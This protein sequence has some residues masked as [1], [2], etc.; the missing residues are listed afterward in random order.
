MIKGGIKVEKSEIMKNRKRCNNLCSL[1]H[2][3]SN[4]YIGI[5][6]KYLIGNEKFFI[7]FGSAPTD[8]F[9][10]GI[11]GSLCCVG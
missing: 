5:N 4:S 1:L 9:F 6:G 11:G 2:L 3:I 7:F 10:R 8:P